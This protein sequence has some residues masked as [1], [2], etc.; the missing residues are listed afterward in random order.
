VIKKDESVVTFLSK[1]EMKKFWNIKVKKREQS[2]SRLKF[3]NISNELKEKKLSAEFC[4]VHYTGCI[5][6]AAYYLCHVNLR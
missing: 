2:E 4:K 1:I 5:Q 3:P 6:N